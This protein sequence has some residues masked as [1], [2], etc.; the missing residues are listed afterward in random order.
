MVT[1][2]NIGLCIVLT[3]VTCGLYGLYW[4]ITLTDDSLAVSGNSGN[5]G[6]ISLVL[7]FVTCGLYMFYWYYKL[8]ENV[9]TMNHNRGVPSSNTGII[10]ILLAVF[11]LGIISYCMAQDK[12]NQ[13]L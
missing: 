5:S 13:C 8:G 12:I 2:K 10:Y 6:I 1:N 7:T 3:F 4:F 9:D 11:G